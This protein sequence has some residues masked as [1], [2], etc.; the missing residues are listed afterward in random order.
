MKDLLRPTLALLLAM[1]L[2]LIGQTTP[3]ADPSQDTKT[4]EEL[5]NEI[6][7]YYNEQF[8]EQSNSLEDM[9]AGQESINERLDE[10]KSNNELRDISDASDQD[11]EEELYVLP[12]F[13]VSNDQDEGY[14]SAN[15]TSVTRT[16]TLVK[17]SPISMSIVNEQLLDD[18][19]ILSTQDLAMVSAAI[20][21][22]PNGFSLDRIRIRG[23]RNSFSRFNFF[24]RNLPTDSYNIGRVDIIKGANSL[25]FV[26]ASP[27]GSV[28]NA[29]MLANFRDNTKAVSAAV[30]NKDYL[31]TTFNANQ[32]INDNFAIRVMGVHSEQGYDHLFKSNELDALTVAT[33][34]RLTP[35]TQLRLHLEG[36]NATNR[37][38]LLEATTTIFVMSF[39]YRKQCV[40]LSRVFLNFPQ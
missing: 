18:L 26:Q 21:E 17:N 19:N 1:P 22:D 33:T 16:N 5:V 13:V 32:I 27:G 4:Y 39:L 24:K 12:E 35:K 29:P 37:H 40:V 2:G 8:P 31:R 15:S 20:D 23:F 14:Y 10:Y 7:N 36:V 6:D 25:I 9:G 11:I 38:P 3:D 34:M 30:G 28:S